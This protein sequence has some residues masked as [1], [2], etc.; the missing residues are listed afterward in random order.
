LQPQ[1]YGQASNAKAEHHHGH[2][3]H[4]H[5]HGHHGYG[6]KRNSTPGQGKAQAYSTSPYDPTNQTLLTVHNNVAF[7]RYRSVCKPGRHQS[8][9]ECWHVRL[10]QRL[11]CL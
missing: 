9:L 5:G 7:P 1:A 6:D 10:L 3:G 4:K 2:H 11:W 8:R